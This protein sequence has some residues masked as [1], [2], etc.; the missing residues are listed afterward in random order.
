MKKT[1][2]L[3]ATVL[4]VGTSFAQYNNKQMGQDKDYGYNKGY[5]NDKFDRG[6]SKT[7]F[8]TAKERDMQIMQINKEYS[9]QIQSVKMKFF[10]PRGAK[11]RQIQFLEQKRDKEISMVW[12]KYNDQ[13]NI[14]DGRGG[15]NDR[16]RGKW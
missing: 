4:L 14:G 3:L 1:I 7:Y 9:K 16:G 10:M 13:D 8:F 5:D 15:R 2:L 12:V 11:Q 6:H